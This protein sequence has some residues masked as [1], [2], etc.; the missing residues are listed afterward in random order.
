MTV[1]KHIG[2]QNGERNSQQSHNDDSRILSA[3]SENAP[4]KQIFTTYKT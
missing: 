1:E 4:F 2:Y 3:V